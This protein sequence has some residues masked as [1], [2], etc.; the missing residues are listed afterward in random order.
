VGGSDESAPDKGIGSN[1]RCSGMKH[2][3]ETVPLA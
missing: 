1:A 3:M 2:R